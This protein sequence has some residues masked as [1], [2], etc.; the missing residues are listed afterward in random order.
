[1]GL[2]RRHQH[3][4]GEAHYQTLVSTPSTKFR[5]VPDLSQH[6]GGCPGDAVPPCHNPHSADVEVLGG[7]QEGVIGTSASSPDIAGLFALKIA[8]TGSRL[9]WENVDIYTRAQKQNKGSGKPYHHT[10]ITGNNGH[11]A[12]KVPYDLVIGNGS[13]DAR[14]FL[15][16][17]K[18]PAAGIPGTDSNP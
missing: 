1:M 11:Y 12:T 14:Q 3:L 13:V 17:T 18:L 8:L 4:L 2:R 6:M 16:E 5:T 9:G 15:G 7:E 10:G